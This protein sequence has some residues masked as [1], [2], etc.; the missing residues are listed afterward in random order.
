MHTVTPDGDRGPNGLDLAAVD[1]TMRDI[2]RH[3]EIAQVRLRARNRWIDGARSRSLSQDFHAALRRLPHL[4]SFAFELDYPQ[5]LG[6]GDVG[7]TPAEFVLYGL[8][9]DVTAAV[10]LVAGERDVELTSIEVEVEGS[11]DARPVLGL[12]GADRSGYQHIDVEV[13]LEGDAGL[14][15]LDAIVAA[16]RQR[17]PV[18]DTITSAV[19]VRV[20]CS[21]VPEDRG[22]GLRQTRPR[23][24]P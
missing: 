21:R 15:E 23:A 22:C 24:H 2:K 17:S 12:T 6:G 11:M 14:E 13:A 16:A 7:P 9:G 20:R 5:L 18:V 1:D 3:P 10:A 8:A 4:R 19:P